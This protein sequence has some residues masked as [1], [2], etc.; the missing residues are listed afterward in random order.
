MEACHFSTWSR[1]LFS[2]PLH[3]N[4]IIFILV[5]PLPHTH[6]GAAAVFVDLT[7]GASTLIGSLGN[8]TSKTVEHKY[9]HPSSSFHPLL[10]SPSSPPT[11][12]TLYNRF[13]IARCKSHFHC[14]ITSVR[15]NCM[16]IL[17]FC[18]GMGRAQAK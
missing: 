2:R 1:T 4:A 13:L 11:T 6:T 10:P 16:R 8:E 9:A 3:L 12:L 5:N 15:V 17:L 18:A 7:K 14:R